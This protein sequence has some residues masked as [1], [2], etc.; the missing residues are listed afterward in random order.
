M[1]RAVMGKTAAR[2]CGL[3]AG[4]FP[5]L[6]DDELLR[7]VAY[8][9]RDALGALFTRF[10]NVVFRFAF[11]MSG[12]VSLAEDVT[13]ETFIVLMRSAARYQ[14]RNAK[15]STYLYAIVRN[16]T[17][18]RLNKEA[19]ESR[20]GSWIRHLLGTETPPAEQ[21]MIEATERRDNIER[22]RQA[23]LSLPQRYREVVVLCD[24]H[25][26]DYAE[27]SAIIGCPVGTVRSRLHRG[28]DLLRGKLGI[29]MRMSI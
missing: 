11:Q 9:H 5:D 19:R 8:G 16:L 6:T 17:R 13:Q 1:R 22:V 20:N 14:P 23:V 28:R 10:Q 4:S 26:R 24:L 18:K 2:R 7:L 15:V 21:N 27:A 25:G 3:L 12:N 29:E